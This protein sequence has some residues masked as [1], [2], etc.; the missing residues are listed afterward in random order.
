[1]DPSISNMRA[2]VKENSTEGYELKE[3]PVPTIEAD[4]ILFKVER[5]AICGSDIA[6]Y[7]WNEVAKVIGTIP[8]IPG[9]EAAGTVVK[10]GSDVV[11]VKEGDRLAI[12][13]HFFCE[14]CYSCE[15]G[16]G[17]ICAK[18][19]QYGHGKGTTQGGFSEY[20][21]VK[22]K[23]CYVLKTDISFDDAV[24]LEPMG[25]AFNGVNRINTLGKEVLIIG[26]GAIG[27]LAAACA[28]ALGASKV[29][30]ADINSERLQLAKTM[31][32]DVIINSRETNLQS[33]VMRLTNGDGVP[34][35]V[36]ASGNAQVVNSCFKLLQKGAELVFIGLHR[37]PFHVDDFLNDIVFKSLTLHTVHGKMK[38]YVFI[39]F[40][41]VSLSKK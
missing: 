26:A 21:V 25:V 34:R 30:V 16:R 37:Q 10:V 28:K 17:D 12:E 3:I 27:L 31:G 38:L 18:M 8:F 9:H 32:A 41:P 40:F 7:L 1:M 36:E 14:D 6:L 35:L 24:L 4:E 22:S 2:L 29:L 39:L 19:N 33:E 20:S 13:N 23:Y 15:N 11:D 5:V